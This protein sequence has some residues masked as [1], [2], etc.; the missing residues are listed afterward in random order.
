MPA[1]ATGPLLVVQMD[2]VNNMGSDC[3]KILIQHGMM[4]FSYLLDLMLPPIRP[5]NRHLAIVDAVQANVL[6]SL[7]FIFGW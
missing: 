6:L 2:G 7:S 5:S 3:R 4:L 1:V